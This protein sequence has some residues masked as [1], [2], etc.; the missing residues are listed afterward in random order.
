MP[1]KERYLRDKEYYTKY[2]KEHWHYYINNE[3]CKE[4]KRKWRK[5]N[6]EWDKNYFLNNHN[7]EEWKISQRKRSTIYKKTEKG[8]AT[9][10]RAHTKRRA[11]EKDIINTLTA[12]EW[13]D[14]L[15]AYNY[16]CAYCDIEFE[17]ENML[18]KDHVI[19]ISKGGHNIKENI[20]PACRIC[21]SKKHDKLNYAIKVSVI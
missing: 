19:P 2:N 9:N 5:E 1:T 20:V 10:Q 4:Q 13:T 17:V 7:T 14:I 12:Q 21:N 16:R 6:P 18:H 11:I 3:Q 8:K 15:E